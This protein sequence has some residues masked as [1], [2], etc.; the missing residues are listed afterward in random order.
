MIRPGVTSHML[1]TPPK[2]LSRTSYTRPSPYFK[3]YVFRIP[4]SVLFRTS[5][6]AI[7]FQP[8]LKDP[9]LSLSYRRAPS[10]WS[11]IT[12]TQTAKAMSKESDTSSSEF[13]R[14]QQKVGTVGK[15]D[16]HFAAQLSSAQLCRFRTR[17]HGKV[18]V[19]LL[20]CTFCV[21]F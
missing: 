6:I 14:F 17:H 3:T 5:Q 18:P 20:T 11:Q 21:H 4:R 19:T 7:T 12:N 16:T 9:A 13:R 1:T 15:K 8:L 10:Y 2:L